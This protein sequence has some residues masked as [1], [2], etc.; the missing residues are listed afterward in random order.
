[1]IAVCYLVICTLAFYVIAIWER[2]IFITETF[3]FRAL[4]KLVWRDSESVYDF[5]V[6]LLGSLFVMYILWPLFVPQILADQRRV[7]SK[8]K[9]LI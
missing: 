7:W 3:S 6:D 5:M 2:H 8:W 9:Y 4:I 1:M